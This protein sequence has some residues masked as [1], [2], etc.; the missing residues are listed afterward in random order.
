MSR[1][2]VYAFALFFCAVAPAAVSAES[3]G[4]RQVSWFEQ[5]LSWAPLQWFSSTATLALDEYW[6][7]PPGG[8]PCLIE[9]LSEL[10]DPDALAFEE[11]HE[12]GGAVQ[13][14]RLTPATAMALSRFE[15]IVSS[16]GGSVALTSAY[17]PPAY[18]AHLQ[19]V[20]DKWMLDLRDSYAAECQD[21]RA[22]VEREFLDHGLLET[23]RPASVSDHTRGMAFDAIVWLPKRGKRTSRRINMDT[24]ARRAGLFRP[25]AI[26]DPVHFRLVTKRSPSLRAGRATQNRVRARV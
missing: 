9:P 25:V 4:V 19:E 8:P 22:E 23:Q 2:L 3:T 15:A 16:L 14:A 26:L 7:E 17:R 6:P 21:L 5:L 11:D 12:T 1:L 20:W 18:Q 24:L 13:T 10:T